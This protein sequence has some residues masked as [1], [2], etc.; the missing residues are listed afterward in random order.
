MVHPLPLEEAEDELSSDTIVHMNF[1]YSLVG[2][3]WSSSALLAAN[4]LALDFI[5][6]ANLGVETKNKLLLQLQ[7][8]A[9]WR[10]SVSVDNDINQET[11]EDDADLYHSIDDAITVWTYIIVY[12]ITLSPHH[13]Q[14][15][16]GY[17]HY[18][19]PQT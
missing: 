5:E 10:E 4:I 7:G 8:Q 18:R 19:Q 14:M 17:Y 2:Y 16:L 3:I 15:F 11:F 13:L 6:N 1:R 12:D 9:N